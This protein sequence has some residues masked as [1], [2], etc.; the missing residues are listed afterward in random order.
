MKR[1]VIQNN[2]EVQNDNS[3]ALEK[4]NFLKSIENIFTKFEKKY[5]TLEKGHQ[6]L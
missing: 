2:S 1:L 3:V 5:V 4:K 6:I